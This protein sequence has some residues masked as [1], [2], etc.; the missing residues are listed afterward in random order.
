MIADGCYM[1]PNNTHYNMN[2][3]S[4]AFLLYLFRQLSLLHQIQVMLEQRNR[5]IIAG[6]ST[7]IQ[8]DQTAKTFLVM[9][10]KMEIMKDEKT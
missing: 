3:S 10:N 7:K 9:D 8:Q 2:S 4:T 5:S 1:S 6:H